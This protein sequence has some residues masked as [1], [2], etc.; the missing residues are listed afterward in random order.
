M[1]HRTLWEAIDSDRSRWWYYPAFI[2]LSL[3]LI[4]GIVWLIVWSGGR[5]RSF[6]ILAKALV[7]VVP[8]IMLP[9]LRRKATRSALQRYGAV[10]MPPEMFPDT[11][12]ALH[13]VSL[14]VGMPS[15][16]DLH[17][18]CVDSLNAL[19]TH[20]RG[21]L[22]VAVTEMF[23]RLPREEQ[24]AGFAM[25][26]GRGTIDVDAILLGSKC[27]APS[28]KNGFLGEVDLSDPSVRMRVLD[29]WTA[30]AAAGD[31]Q[32]L[33]RLH[34]PAPLL[35]LLKRLV[36][37]S[38]RLDGLPVMA[39][40]GCLAW[41]YEDGECPEALRL[42]RLTEVVPAAER[43]VA[44]PKPLVERVKGLAD[45]AAPA[46]AVASVATGGARRP[47]PNPVHR[48][49]RIS[50]TCPKCRAN[51]APTNKRCIACGAS[52]PTT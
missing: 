31:R 38:C 9:L 49:P 17:L 32:A 18:L 23:T 12:S 51:N 46:V 8:G 27:G 14:M 36:S 28:D 15:P 10:N 1:A 42:G 50:R 37:G 2:S 35:I 48:G 25:L 21:R 24:R 52:M 29:G 22:K 40:F 11:R 43:D 5:A 7:L 6:E 19:V 26:F 4:G 45:A 30:V 34:E 39:S 44:V 16:P 20:E 47:V 13:D 33:L 41:P 3:I